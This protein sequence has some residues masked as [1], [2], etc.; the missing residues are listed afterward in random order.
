MGNLVLSVI[1]IV[2]IISIFPGYVSAQNTDV[3]QY[4]KFSIGWDASKTSALDYDGMDVGGGISYSGFSMGA[5]YDFGIGI[6]PLVQISY[7][8]VKELFLGVDSESK[9]WYFMGGIRLQSP[10]SS[11][12]LN[13][14]SGLNRQG[15]IYLS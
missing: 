15:I 10:S 9:I 14:L 13:I 1:L 5:N 6:S 2:G 11:V 8:G 7:Y 12:Y 4:M 3:N